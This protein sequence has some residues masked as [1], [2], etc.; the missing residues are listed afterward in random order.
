M[1]RE[2]EHL[3]N[4]R[5]VIAGMLLLLSVLNY[6][7]R[8]ALAILATTI[9]KDLGLDDV[10]YGRISQAFLFCYA[11]TYLV[12]G[13]L[14]DRIL[15]RRAETLFVSVWSTANILTGFAS[16]FFS[17][18]LFRS[19]LGMSEPGHYAVAAKSVGK[20][21]SPAERGVAVAMYSM[22]GTLGAAIAAPLVAW[23]TYF[24]GWRAAFI[25]TGLLG[26]GAALA[27]WLIYRDDEVPLGN[28]ESLRSP[29]PWSSLRRRALWIIIFTR[30][31]TDPVWYFYLVWFAKFLQERRGFTLPEVGSWLWIVFL[32]ADAGCLAAGYL[33]GRLVRF[34][35]RPVSARLVVMSFCAVV[36]AFSFT[37]RY[38]QSPPEVIA[39]ASLFA[40]SILAF[41]TCAV[42]L[43]IDL[44]PT[45]QLGTVQGMIGTGGSLGG[46]ISTGL[47][48]WVV[49]AFSYDLVFLVLGI[50]HPMALGMLFLFRD[51][52]QPQSSATK[53]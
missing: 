50:L 16:G 4:L 53:V 44:F 10:A 8:Q 17:L 14:V 7:D 29:S 12:S 25:A 21:F 34:G 20:L 9:Q 26:Y 31:L 27:W 40:A 2:G 41:M 13:R 46:M 11:A 35:Y 52:L 49:T 15:P 36:L 47:V 24:Y 18:L 43:P 45:E 32:S 33:T 23:L 22:G 30:L 48:A 28:S 6:I 3:A 1:S 42:A 5:W 37:M 38:A 51:S 39:L 19:L